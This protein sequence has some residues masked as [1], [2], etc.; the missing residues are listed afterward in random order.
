L[1]KETTDAIFYP[2]PT[3][4]KLVERLCPSKTDN[5]SLQ[6][7]QEEYIFFCG[8]SAWSFYKQKLSQLHL[9]DILSFLQEK[10][11]F[12]VL[13]A[14]DRETLYKLQWLIYHDQNNF[15]NTKENT[16]L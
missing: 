13:S 10:D 6:G 7:L 4:V 14:E 5:I 3:S 8:K 12:A 1:F 11:A 2:Y 16:A 15:N 9:N